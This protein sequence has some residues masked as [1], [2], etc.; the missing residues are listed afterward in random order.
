MV[1]VIALGGVPRRASILRYYYRAA[2]REVPPGTFDEFESAGINQERIRR[3]FVRQIVSL[4][5]VNTFPFPS[6]SLITRGLVAPHQRCRKIRYHFVSNNQVESVTGNIESRSILL[7]MFDGRT[8][9]RKQL[10]LTF[11]QRRRQVQ[12]VII[13]LGSIEHPLRFFDE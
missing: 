10:P 4:K 3:V 13:K 12:N 2:G 5:I 9:F 8:E 6:L 11:N 7:E 1:Q